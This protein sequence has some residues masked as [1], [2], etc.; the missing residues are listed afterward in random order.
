MT[1]G[2][3]SL[4]LALWRLTR[5]WSFGTAGVWYAGRVQRTLPD[6]RVRIRFCHGKVRLHA[7][8]SFDVIRVKSAL[9]FGK[10]QCGPYTREYARTLADLSESIWPGK[11]KWVAVDRESKW[12][13][14]RVTKVASNPSAW[15]V[16]ENNGQKGWHGAT[17]LRFLKHKAPHLLSG[18]YSPQF[19]DTISVKAAPRTTR[20]AKFR[21]VVKGIKEQTLSFMEGQRVIGSAS[22]KP[23]EWWMGTIVSVR[24]DKGITIIQFDNGKRLGSP[25]AIHDFRPITPIFTGQSGPY[26]LAQA[27]RIWKK[28]RLTD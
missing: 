11:S 13:V 3:G 20:I 4:V 21:P 15:H 1:L 10:H 26:T 22:I 25:R 9:P 7:K 14:G 6:G 17:S 18:P 27:E 5:V 28:Y 23:N 12:Y 16:A 19:I 8:D 2:K 24:R